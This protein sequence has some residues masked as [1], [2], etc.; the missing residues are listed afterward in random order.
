MFAIYGNALENLGKEFHFKYVN[1]DD[2]ELCKNFKMN[3][4]S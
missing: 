2:T 3:Q 4:N 1:S